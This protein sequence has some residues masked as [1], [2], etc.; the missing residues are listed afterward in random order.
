MKTTGFPDIWKELNSFNTEER[1]YA[2]PD[3]LNKT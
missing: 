1:V 3:L 2:Y